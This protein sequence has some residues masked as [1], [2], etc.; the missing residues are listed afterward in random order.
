VASRS[1]VAPDGTLPAG[2]LINVAT[3]RLT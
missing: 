3:T 1:L 2:A